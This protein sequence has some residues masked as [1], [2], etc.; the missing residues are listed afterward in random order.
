[1]AADFFVLPSR[2]EGLPL[3]VLEAMARSL[4][5]VVTPVGG[6]PEVVK[7]REHGLLVPVDDDR[8]LAAAIETIA[9][10]LALRSALGEAG[11]RRVRD[12]FS[13]ERMTRKYEDLYLG[14]LGGAR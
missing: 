9:R 5:V 7:D 1:M 2:D 13:F 4:P 10:D 3:A 11:H 6:V 14:L 12:H 8:A